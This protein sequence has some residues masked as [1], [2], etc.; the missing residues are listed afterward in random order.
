M[1][2]DSNCSHI[3]YELFKFGRVLSS[4][5]GLEKIAEKIKEYEISGLIICGGF[6]VS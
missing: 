1:V 6:E 5:Y 4:K 2:G 3:L